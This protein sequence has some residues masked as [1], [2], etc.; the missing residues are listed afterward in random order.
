MAEI[1]KENLI[2]MGVI[3]PEDKSE[4]DS[5]AVR[6]QVKVRDAE[7]IKALDAYRREKRLT[8]K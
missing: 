7:A 5:D 1:T 6:E 4:F 2:A 8:R 3:D